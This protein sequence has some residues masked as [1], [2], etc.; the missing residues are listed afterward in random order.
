METTVTAQ[1]S[2]DY[3]LD[4]RV[5]ADELEPRVT[6]A[7]KKQR[8]GM[9]LKGF[10]P[11]HVP[12]SYARKVAGP[13]VAVQVAEEVIAEAFRD[14][15]AEQEDYDVVGSPR[16]AELDF[17]P[18]ADADLHA[19]VSFG[20]RPDFDLAEMEGVPVTKFVR[21]F[22]DEDVDAEVE[23][24]RARAATLEPAEEGA[25]LG[26]GDVA[27]V[28]IQ[29]VGEDGEPTGPSQEGAQLI[30][31]DPGL[32]PELKSALL[33][34][35]VGDEFQVDLPHQHAEDEDAD[36][37]DHVDR[38]RIEVTAISRRILPEMDEAFIQEQTDGAHSTLDELKSSV[39]E[40][41][42]RSW[43]QRATQA[44]EGKMVEQFVEAHPFEVPAVLV[45]STLDAMLDEVGQRQGGSL[46]A[47][48]DAGAWRDAQRE[49]AEKQ[50]RWLLVKQ[51]L[52]EEEGIEVTKEDFDAEFEGLASEGAPLDA[53]KG[54]FA[55]QPELLEQMGQH[56]LNRRVFE[57]LGERFTVVEKSREDLE[58]EKAE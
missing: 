22:T 16:L 52:V 40:E 31:A 28:T 58:S 49:Q 18:K 35:A 57:S 32:R 53:V 34:K 8:S 23:G 3:T 45:E 19:V 39:R 50:V 29:P 44:L 6:A 56:I 9:N 36:H 14:T 17:D 4:I 5:P 30:L 11:G 55:Q 43:E 13:Q 38:Y 27:E 20:V 46:P 54:Y 7:L 33:E 41:L 51:K 12:L 1:N 42:E 10:R 37:D 15:V 48:F 2:V 26:E 25:A 21:T 24:M 47:G